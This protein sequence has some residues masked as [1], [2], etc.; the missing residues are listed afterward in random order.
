MELLVGF[1][2][3]GFQR[4]VKAV[5]LRVFADVEGRAWVLFGLKGRIMDN[6]GW[7]W[8]EGPTSF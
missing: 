3:K 5:G 8:G 4:L 2:A 1:L 6:M 7:A